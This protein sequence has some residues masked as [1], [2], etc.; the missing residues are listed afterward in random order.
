MEST[1]LSSEEESLLS[2]EEDES[3]SVSSLAVISILDFD[4]APSFLAVPSPVIES[5]ED[6]ISK[7]L[8][9][10]VVGGM[11]IN[12]NLIMLRG[13][14][15]NCYGARCICPMDRLC[16]SAK[17]ALAQWSR[18]RWNFSGSLEETIS[19]FFSE[20]GC[21]IKM[22]LKKWLSDRLVGVALD[23]AMGF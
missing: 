14:K 3:E 17:L 18:V 9:K 21:S 1:L 11:K 13:V 6:I 10:L 22:T 20:Y 16:T 5:G 8:E 19:S 4:A 7:S 23:A 2:S 15:L 12:K